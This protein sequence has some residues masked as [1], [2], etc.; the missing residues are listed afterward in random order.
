MTERENFKAMKQDLKYKIH[1]Y[2]R[3]QLTWFRRFPEIKWVKNKKE[4]E[5]F[6][7]GFLTNS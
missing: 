4:A 7:V 6:A 5:E 1:A 2:A 3:R